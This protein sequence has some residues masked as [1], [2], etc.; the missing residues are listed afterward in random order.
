MPPREK[1]K[2]NIGRPSSYSDELAAR[3]CAELACGKSL[4]TVCK[5]EGMPSLETIFRWLREKPE[6][7]DQYAHAKNESADALVEEMLDIADDA[8]GDHDDEGRFVSENVQRSKLRID[9]RKWIAAKMK[10]KKFGDQIDV[11]HGGQ[12]DNPLTALIMSVQGNVLRPVSQH[13]IEADDD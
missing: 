4:R 11:N 10:P 7:R 13:L 1:S 12:N 9:T 8:S 6:F 5:P 2:P 3:I